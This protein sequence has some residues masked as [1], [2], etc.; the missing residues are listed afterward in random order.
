M[1]LSYI[2]MI[3][4]EIADEIND[5]LIYGKN[6]VDVDYDSLGVSPFCNSRLTEYYFALTV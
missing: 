6:T 5:Y 3:I 1:S 2:L 4:K